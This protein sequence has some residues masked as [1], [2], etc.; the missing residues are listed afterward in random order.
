MNLLAGYRTKLFARPISFALNM[1]N[2][3]NKDYYVSGAANIG[4]WG[5]PQNFRF[6]SVVDF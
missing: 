1:D 3:L 6:S 4:K 2:V 5:V